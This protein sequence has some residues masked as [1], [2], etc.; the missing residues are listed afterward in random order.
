M[1]S[2]SLSERNILLGIT[3]SVAAYK[4]AELVRRLRDAGADVRVIMSHNATRFLGEQTLL[5]LSGN[6]VITDLF[7]SGDEWASNHISLSQWAH[8]LL[9]APASANIIG[10]AASG[11]ADDIVSTVILSARCKVV[12]APA[13]NAAMYQNPIVQENIGKLR[14]A[15]CEFI[16]P[17][18]GALACGEEGIGRL[19]DVS[20]I[21]AHLDNIL[22][23]LR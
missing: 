18:T 7:G 22:K 17:E 8:V 2:G 9:I 11:I 4:A 19:A 1:S 16:G 12:F 20:S 15:G 6:K 14:R 10:K 5:S 23:H 21:L 13:M 3:G